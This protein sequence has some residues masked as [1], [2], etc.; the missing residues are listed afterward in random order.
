MKRNTLHFD[1][2][3]VYNRDEVGRLD[4][5]LQLSIFQITLESLDASN[6]EPHRTLDNIKLYGLFPQGQTPFKKLSFTVTTSNSI[7]LI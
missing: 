2:R 1:F 6:V 3:L 4:V 7:Y 5:H